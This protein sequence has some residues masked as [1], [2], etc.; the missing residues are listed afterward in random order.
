MSQYKS[1]MGVNDFVLCQEHHVPMI[2]SACT[3]VV[4]ALCKSN[5]VFY[6]C[7]VHGC[8]IKVCKSCYKVHVHNKGNQ[9]SSYINIEND[10]ND[11][12]MGSAKKDRGYLFLEDYMTMD[13][14]DS[15]DSNIDDTFDEVKELTL[16]DGEDDSSDDGSESSSSSSLS[17][18]TVNFES[19]L[20]Y[21]SDN[22]D[23]DDDDDSIDR[24]E[25]DFPTTNAGDVAKDIDAFDAQTLRLN[26]HIIL[27]QCGSVLCRHERLLEGNKMQKN[28]L[29]G[30]QSGPGVF[31][32][33]Y[34]H[35]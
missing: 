2:I 11:A 19:Y 10:N 24:K 1:Y 6:E 16:P 4:C 18:D 27:N 8:R 30:T 29:S 35:A 21:T 15:K 3:N 13:N 22:D 20:M 28:F 32:L 26:A 34:R 12:T 14:D 25:D 9:R 23:D 5:K 31:A 17:I 7:A 33:F